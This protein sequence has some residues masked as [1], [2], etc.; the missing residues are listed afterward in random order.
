MQVLQLSVMRACH[1]P[2]ATDHYIY[3]TKRPR[4]MQEIKERR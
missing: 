3:T 2:L 4:P 1:L